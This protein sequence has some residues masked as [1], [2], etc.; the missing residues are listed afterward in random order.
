[1]IK[2]KVLIFFL[3][4]I[5]F[6]GCST[7]PAKYIG[8]LFPKANE[9]AVRDL[10][11]KIDE[12]KEEEN[13]KTDKS[14][15]SNL[16]FWDISDNKKIMNL[17][18]DVI[19]SNDIGESQDSASSILQ[20]TYDN[21]STIY[22]ID[23]DG[24]ITSTNIETGDE[25]WSYDL[26]IDVTSGLAVHN[27]HL[28]FGA[29]DG[30]FYGYKIEHFNRDIKYLEK[31]NIMN[32]FDDSTIQPDIKIQLKSEAVSPAIGIDNLIYVKLSD[33]DT[34]AINYEKEVIEWIHKGRN[35]ALSIKGT[36]AISY[37]YENIYVARDDGNLISLSYDTGKLNWL[38]SIS[39]RS[40]RN[41][42]E[43]LRDIEMSPLIQDGAVY[44]GSY[45]GNLISVDT[46]SG[47]IIWSTPISVYANLAI[48]D[49][50]IYATSN[51][52]IIYAIDRYNGNKVW[53]A[54]FNKNLL[55]PQP[56]VFDN[57]VVSFSTQGDLIV[58]DKNNGKTIH[59][60]ELL[61][62]I[63]YQSNVLFINKILY[64]VSRNGRLNAIKI[65]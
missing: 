46:I 51:D 47:N 26:D 10:D 58:L 6:V 21:Q 16:I 34:V 3:F 37:D 28:F 53:E 15:F 9:R 1:M 27:N 22:T 19:W 39:P 45:Q 12:R 14:F 5:L 32:V 4:S 42:L 55:F 38:V 49:S 8:E 41:E 40:G 30:V 7:N 57:Y 25:N 61:D 59:F 48:D 54:Q 65:N 56:T 29:S 36:A 52:G 24:A 35:I 31:L 13:K 62:E 20:P 50:N 33:G 18:P 11:V 60:E 23:T 2:S 63:D 43:S 44:V 64:I 17:N